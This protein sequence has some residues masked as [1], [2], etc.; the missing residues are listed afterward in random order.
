MKFKLT[1]DCDHDT[2]AENPGVEVGG[3][4]TKWQNMLN[5]C[6]Y[7]MGYESSPHNSIRCIPDETGAETPVVP[8][9][10]SNE[11]RQNMMDL[12]TIEHKYGVLWQFDTARYTVAFWAED[13]DMDPADGF[14]DQ[15]DIEFASTGDPAHWFCAF[16]G[17]FNAKGTCLG[18]DVLGG[19]SYNSFEEFYS[20]HRWRYSRRQKR[21]VKDPRS[22]AW[23]TNG[24]AYCSTY[25]VSMVHRAIREARQYNIAA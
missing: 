16:V 5:S 18:Y 12:D 24:R 21:F 13:E 7:P 9:N 14:T 20:S 17:V 15:R 4:C 22:R 8:T 1:I 19:C 11:R 25:F 3:F 6:I 23:K 10:S 2:F